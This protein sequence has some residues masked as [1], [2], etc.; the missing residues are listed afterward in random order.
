M[1]KIMVTGAAI[2]LTA[3][4]AGY[5]FAY[6]PGKLPPFPSSLPF[7]K[8]SDPRPQENLLVILVNDLNASPPILES[9]WM[10][11]IYRG[12][13][14]S[15]VFLPIYSL[16]AKKSN[17]DLQDGFQYGMFGKISSKFWNSLAEDYQIRWDHYLI[18]DNVGLSSFYEQ[19][20]GKKPPKALK[21]EIVEAKPADY[22]AIAQKVI[23]AFCGKL[24]NGVNRESQNVDW[25][26]IESNL[27]TNTKFEIIASEWTRYLKNPQE[28]PCNIVSVK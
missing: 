14:P 27:K 21:Q 6:L 15:L 25:T 26:R 28:D 9:I 16:K 7:E 24:K 5:F 3:L 23:K 19:L 17:P 10:V 8:K 20:T 22:N 12:N 11:Y 18:I 13:Q 2:F 1:R 4:L